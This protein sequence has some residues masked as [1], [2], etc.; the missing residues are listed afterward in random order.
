LDFN[1]NRSVHNH[2]NHHPQQQQQQ[3]L[4]TTTPSP[5]KAY[6]LLNAGLHPHDF[7]NPV[8]IQNV[9]DALRDMQLYG[10]WKTTTYTKVHV[11]QEQLQNGIIPQ[12][13]QQQLAAESITLLD[14]QQNEKHN[15]TSTALSDEYMCQALLPHQCF[16][17]SWIIRLKSP[18]SQYYVDHSKNPNKVMVAILNRIY[19]G[20]DLKY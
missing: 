6:V 7:Y 11:L 10:T 2:H 8:T 9:V 3:Q 4:S 12:Q 17:V 16:N 18:I 1:Y 5:P 19:H 20:I 14:V 13:Q 15:V